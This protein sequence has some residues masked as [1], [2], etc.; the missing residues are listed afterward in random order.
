MTMTQ[1]QQNAELGALHASIRQAKFLGRLFR[2]TRQP[3]ARKRLNQD[4]AHEMEWA[5]RLVARLRLN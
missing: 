2:Y 1:E 5:A 4:R 3:D